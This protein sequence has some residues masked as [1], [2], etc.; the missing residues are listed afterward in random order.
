MLFILKSFMP[1]VRPSI[2]LKLF[3]TDPNDFEVKQK[4]FR[5]V[6]KKLKP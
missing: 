2:G 4:Q 1:Y 5:P 3:L 6:L